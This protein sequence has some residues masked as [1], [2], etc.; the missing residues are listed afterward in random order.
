[1]N[2]ASNQL[3]SLLE[4][5]DFFEPS[6]LSTI[7][8]EFRELREEAEHRSKKLFFKIGLI[9]KTLKESTNSFL[10]KIESFPDAIHLHN[11]NLA[12]IESKNVGDRINPV[13]GRDLDT[14]QLSSI[15][16]DVDTR[17]VI[18]GAGRGRQPRS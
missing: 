17:L 2:K 5:N 1:M 10:K 8:N 6:Q 11:R 16:M 14:Q 4:N 13:E 3:S 18:A 9:N 15:A 7:E 12:L